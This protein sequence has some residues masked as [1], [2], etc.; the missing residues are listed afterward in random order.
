MGGVGDL[1]ENFVAVEQGSSFLERAVLGFDD[2]EEQEPEFECEPTA[3]DDL[4]KDIE[5]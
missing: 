2:E 4:C 5:D 3:V 1:V